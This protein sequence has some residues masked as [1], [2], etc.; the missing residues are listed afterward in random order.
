[1]FAVDNRTGAMRVVAPL[2]RETTPEYHVIVTCADAPAGSAEA[3]TVDVT[4]H[5][6]EMTSLPD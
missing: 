5:V 4:V 3:H 1:V 2:D 6:I